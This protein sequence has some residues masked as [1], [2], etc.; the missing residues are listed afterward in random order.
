M[1]CQRPARLVKHPTELL[2]SSRHA[3]KSEK[4][5]SRTPSWSEKGMGPYLGGVSA[6]E[7][8][9][10][11]RVRRIDVA[12]EKGKKR[13]DTGR[14]GGESKKGLESKNVKH[15]YM[16]RER[17]RKK[18][19]QHLQCAGSFPIPTQLQEPVSQLAKNRGSYES[20][21]KVLQ[22]KKRNVNFRGKQ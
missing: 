7:K 15:R 19:R 4:K 14:T 9:P 11:P 8:G 6:R 5:G 21:H 20:S 22:L 10:V 12:R 17:K 13:E 1:L 16:L 3:K 18:R 2:K